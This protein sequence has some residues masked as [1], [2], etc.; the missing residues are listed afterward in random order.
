[1]KLLFLTQVLDRQDAVLGF[2]PRWIEG[3][4][5]RVERLRVVALEVGDTEGLPANVD[6]RE[7]G[8]RGMLG[9]YLRYR[10]VL[11]AAL[12]EEGFDAVLAH[13]VPRYALVAERPARRAGAGLFLWYTHKGVDRRLRLAVPR[14]DLVFTAS[15]ESLRLEAPNKVVTGHGI[16]L[17]HFPLTELP[18]GRTRLLSVGRMTPAKDPLTILAAVEQLVR[19]GQDVE[20]ELVGGGLAPGDGEYAATVRAK[21]AAAGLS[22]RV[23]LCGALPYL[24]VPAAYQRAHLV[25]NSSHT[26]SVDKVV[27]EAFA[28]GRAV[29]S[30]NESIPPLLAELGPEAQEFQFPPGNATALAARISRCLQRPPAERR[31][32]AAQLRSIVARDHEVEALMQRLVEH[33]QRHLAGARA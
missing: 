24:E 16:D 27:L 8:R 30:C 12:A 22:S 7:I 21:I 13:M 1:V 28:S 11:K 5:K 17:E 3:L 10:R 6:W 32:W 33:M 29:L 23:H 26:G 31:A 18:S 14:C 2:V 25:I 4:A 9:R 15:P 20:L 19:A